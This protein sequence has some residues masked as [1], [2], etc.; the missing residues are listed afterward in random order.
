MT[1]TAV[2]LVQMSQ[3]LNL[4][5]QHMAYV[6]PNETTLTEEL[7]A[8][9]ERLIDASTA[10]RKQA[11]RE[12]PDELRTL[13]QSI[14]GVGVGTATTR[15]AEIGDIAK[16]KDAKAL[17]AY[18]GLDCR[19]RQSG[20]TLQRNTRLTVSEASTIHCSTHRCSA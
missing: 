6:L 15:I 18:A 8:C 2:K 3:M 11:A 19:V 10:F 7:K 4:M 20:K 14:P 16:F 9:R 13:L 5:Q 1:R 12:T 17:V